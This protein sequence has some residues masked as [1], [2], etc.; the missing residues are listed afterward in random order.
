MSTPV[1]DQAKPVGLSGVMCVGFR[2]RPHI[3]RTRVFRIKGST[4]HL[5]WECLQTWLSEQ[6]SPVPSHRRLGYRRPLMRR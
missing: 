1:I 4:V 3:V 5:C 2:C 6:D